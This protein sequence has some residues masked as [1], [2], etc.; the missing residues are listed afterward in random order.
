MP[1][2]ESGDR[3]CVEAVHLIGVLGTDD[4]PNSV[5]PRHLMGCPAPPG[6]DS[7]RD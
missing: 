5:S 1:S 4:V 2:A 6:D 7:V 3:A